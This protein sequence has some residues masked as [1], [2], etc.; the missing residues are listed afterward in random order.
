MIEREI[1]ALLFQLNTISNG[2]PVQL[3]QQLVRTT[4]PFRIKDY[5]TSQRVL[6]ALKKVMFFDDTP[7]S[8]A[9]QR[10]V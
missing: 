4:M 5:A 9:L 3:L 10:L 6:N 1:Q 2:K 8:T 7:Y